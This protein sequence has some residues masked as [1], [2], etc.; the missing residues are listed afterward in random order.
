MVELPEQDG[1]VL[2]GRISVSTHPWLVDHAVGQAV[3]FPGTAFVELAV[4]AGD[5]VGSPVLEELT[6][7]TPLVIDG[8]ESVQVQV[9][10]TA[11][12]RDGRRE[13]SV[14]AR[15][16]QRPWTRHATA[17]LT[18]TSTTDHEQWEQW[19]PAGAE[20]VDVSGHYETLAAAGYGYGP[21]FQGLKRA[22]IREG[23][24]FAEVELG[25]QEAAEA[26]RYGIH[27]ALL[28]A[29]LH[30]TGLT[31]LT[32]ELAEGVALPFAWS[33][34][35]LLASGA[36][37][38]R[39]HIVPGEGGAVGIRIADG[40]GAPV[41]IVSSLVSRP[42]PADGLSSRAGNGHEAL[43]R[44]QWV[45]PPS[46]NPP[47][48]EGAIAVIGTVGEDDALTEALHR[49]GLKVRSY[50]DLQSASTDKDVTTLVIP[51]QTRQPDDQGPLEDLRSEL[52]RVVGVLGGWLADERLAE[53]RLVLVTTGAV[54]VETDPD[55]G[56]LVGAA[57][58][59]LVRSAQAENPG[60]ILLIDLDNA[61]ESLTA[62]ASLLGM[63]DEPQVAIRAGRVLVPR[64][65]WAES[66]DDLPLP[67]GSGGWRLDCPVKG[68]LDGLS[69]VPA[70]EA[71]RELASGEVR[72]QV[73]AAGLNF[74]DVVV[75]LGMVPEQGE[76]I[77][78]EFAGVVA[79]VGPEVE[80]L[81]VGDRVMGLG[82][83]AFAPRLVVDQRLLVALP[84]GWS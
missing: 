11:A 1:V 75:T 2:T 6:L 53:M 71:D 4:R 12:G 62:L 57:V 49:N 42:L 18:T 58:S 52:D 5:E 26:A 64:L 74:R 68:S 65:T 60:R 8:E 48:V 67:G 78:G 30:A 32:G 23:E 56:G 41:A 22:W 20:P 50:A 33:G 17:T 66:G 69:L 9:A 83:A 44:L 76:P 46:W 31:G 81:Q 29:C 70:P 15:A 51:C 28:D 10:V 43:H 38:V 59:G 13:V 45:M 7:E 39:V 19:P 47:H 36:Q 3:V 80:G 54:T 82:E 84:A 63:E 27:P 35:E 79:E 24:V 77:G 72:V 34:V 25:E 73:R 21:A 16:G 14:H 55:A 61:A 40:T 37:Q